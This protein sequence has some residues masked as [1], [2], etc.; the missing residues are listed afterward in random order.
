MKKLLCCFSLLCAGLMVSC[1]DKNELVD[2]DSKPSWLGG[3]IY[4]ELKSPSASSGLE[5]TFTT[6]LRLVD[7]L[8]YADVLSR[9]GS[10]TV[11]AAN[12]SAFSEFFKSNDW[13]V[14]SYDELS[15]AQ[16][17]LLLKYSMLDNALLVGMLSNASNGDG[18]GVTAGSVLKHKTSLDVI[19]TVTTYP[20]LSVQ[21]AYGNNSNF[22]E[23]TTG[24]S[25]VNDATTPMLV[26]FTRDYMLN[27]NITTNGTGSDFSLLMGEDYDNKSAYILKTKVIAEDVTCQNGYIHQVRDVLV[28]PGNMAQLIKNTPELSIFSHMLDRFA[29]PVLNTTVTNSYHDWY[30]EQSK[31]ND[32][33]GVYNPDKI[34]EIRYLSNNSQGCAEFKNGGSVSLKFDPGWNEY[35]TS[36]SSTL[37]SIGAMFVPTDDAF[38]EYFL[39]GGGKA[40]INRY[41]TEKPVTLENLKRNTDGMPLNVVST[42]LSNMMVVDFSQAVPSKFSSIVDDAADIMGVSLSDLQQNTDGSYEIKIANNGVIYET[43][44]VLGPKSY[45]AV[46]SPALFENNMKMINWMIQNKSL[47]SGA[48]NKYSLD[49][50]YY[51]YLL[52][53]SSNFALFLPT[54][55]AFATYYI[56][57]AS[58][59]KTTPEAVKYICTVDSNNVSKV[60][61]Q[62]YKYD[63]TTGTVDD[64][65][66]GY[67]GDYNLDNT[68]DMAIVKRHLVDILN[69]HTL[70]LTQGDSISASGANK[71]YKTKHGGEI[72]V[73]RDGSNPVGWYV[74]SGSQI[75][76]TTSSAKI[77]DKY[78]LTNGYSYA[79]DHLIQTPTESIYKVLQS[80]SQFSQFLELCEGFS[81]AI[82]NGVLEWLGI[83]SKAAT[84]STLIPADQYKVFY[85]P[86]ENKTSASQQHCCLDYNVKFLS[87]Y[88]YTVYAPDNDAMTIAYNN[89]LPTWDEVNAEFEARPEDETTADDATKARLLGK[90]DAMLAFVKYHFQNTS[91]YADNTVESGNYATFL[92]NSSNI[93]QT[94]SVSGGDGKIYVK[95]ATS[96]VKTI[97]VN[98]S[99]LS[100]KMARDFEFDANRTS[101]SYVKS[102]C[103][104][105]VHEL[106]TPLSYNAQGKY[107][108]D[109]AIEAKHHK[110]R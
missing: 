67:L 45:E 81:E 101:A 93:S 69:Y 30:E 58:L 103:F 96:T 84:G 5:G 82:D 105:V 7:D 74:A 53:M 76:N 43:S 12:D 22:N 19:D 107:G 40:V 110:N 100:N 42:L 3:S 61:A 99:L 31:V 109:A 50:D 92:S 98:N 85:E 25:V 34:Y 71:Y 35:C 4:D 33:T 57:P 87:N 106:S 64:S 37:S 108:A 16:K 15:D 68:S 38:S 55:E 17:K 18:N 46:S 20:F 21:A 23:F 104:A 79:V 94:L 73:T 88:N 75:G 91:I 51:A 1:V 86:G 26:H 89:G 66:T 62:R 39:N 97:D 77:T 24:L 29:V 8:G 10:K 56:D 48:A 72:M 70:V 83:S 14:T 49:V 60:T 6:Y 36:T 63:P 13:G 78:D 54:D 9:T 11:F 32:M 65:S 44:T 2:E 90:I 28:Q 102:S 41:A 95:D 59:G 27:N 80:N 47:E 52:A